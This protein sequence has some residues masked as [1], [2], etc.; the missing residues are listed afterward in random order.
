MNDRRIMITSVQDSCSSQAA[1]SL[2]DISPQW[3]C[4]VLMATPTMCRT[5]QPKYSNSQVAWRKRRGYKLDNLSFHFRYQASPC[6]KHN[7]LM[8]SLK[9]KTPQSIQW[10]PRLLRRQTKFYWQKDRYRLKKHCQVCQ[11]FCGPKSN[12]IIAMTV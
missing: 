10:Y 11:W 12:N 3:L 4:I 8:P 7:H 6:L 5:M 1:S 2:G 9:P